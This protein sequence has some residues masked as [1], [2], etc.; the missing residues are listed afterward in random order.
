MSMA[1]IIARGE[2]EPKDFAEK[3]ALYR[4][5]EAEYDELAKVQAQ[6]VQDPTIYGSAEDRAEARKVLLASVR[7]YAKAFTDAELSAH[8]DQLSDTE[9]ANLVLH[10]YEVTNSSASVRL[11]NSNSSSQN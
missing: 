10:R 8:G 4:E 5:A 7:H 2:D 3:L 1:E 9:R 6:E 11:L